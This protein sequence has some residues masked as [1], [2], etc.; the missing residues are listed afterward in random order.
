VTRKREVNGMVIKNPDSN[1]TL[2]VA[3]L[4]D[5]AEALKLLD[6]ATRLLSRG[7]SCD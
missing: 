3:I 7:R 5:K 1:E 4:C 2:V 6:A